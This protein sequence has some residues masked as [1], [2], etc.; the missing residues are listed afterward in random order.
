MLPLPRQPFVGRAVAAQFAAREVAQA[1][2][3]P[4]RRVPDD[5][6]AHANLD[7]IGMG[8]EDQQLGGRHEVRSYLIV[9]TGV[10]AHATRP[11]A[12]GSC[13]SASGLG[14]GSRRLGL[15]PI[16]LAPFPFPLAPTETKRAG[17]FSEPALQWSRLA[18]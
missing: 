7:V 18:G 16:P 2:R 4:A 3:H 12:H 5:G 11:R 8:A 14:G 6:A 9:A 15:T 1:H 10:R 17:P 13:P